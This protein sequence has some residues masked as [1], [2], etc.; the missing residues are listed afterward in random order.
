MPTTLVSIPSVPILR[1]GMDY[2][3]SSGKKTFTEEDLAA[4]AA[5]LATDPGVKAPRIKID[6]LAKAW[7]LDPE[8][9]GGEPAFGWFDNL[10][11]SDNGQEL[12]ADAHVPDWVRDAMEWAY[13]SLSIEGTP[14]WQSPSMLRLG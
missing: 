9:H 10:H 6:A 3:L 12:L 1:V 5:A 14:S 2:P 11:V 8:A 7:G 4:A 13:P